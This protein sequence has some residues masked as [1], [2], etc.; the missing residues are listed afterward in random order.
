MNSNLLFERLWTQYTHH[1]PEARQIHDAFVDAGEKVVNDH[2]AFRTFFHPHVNVDVLARPFL[3]AGYVQKGFYL[4]PDKH[5]TAKHFE[6]P[7]DPTAPRVFISQLMTGYFSPALQAT[8]KQCIDSIPEEKTFDHEL[9]FAG[10]LW[11]K[12]SFSVYEAMRKESE[13][14][15]W[16]YVYGFV[17]NHFTVSINQL[18]GLNTIEK[19]NTFLKNK[20]FRLNNSGGEV[21]GNPSELLEQSS[22]MAGVQSV[23]FQEGVYQIPSCYYEFALRYPDA[24]GHL[25]SGFIAK[26][27]DKIFESTNFYTK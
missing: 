6:I 1:N 23:E 27:A 21:K 7:G 5:L 18:K 4:F 25:Y 8:V 17:V 24:D 3:L 10:N 15:A 26:S 16:L 14:A 11:G 9:I 22:T 13:Y 20:G 19:V 2:I 12:P